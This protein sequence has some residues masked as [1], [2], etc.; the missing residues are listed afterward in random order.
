M[1]KSPHFLI[2]FQCL[3]FVLLIQPGFGQTKKINGVVLDENSNPIQGATVALKNNSATKATDAKGNFSFSVNGSKDVLRVTYV[4]YDSKEIEVGNQTSLTISL[5]PKLATLNDIVITALGFEAKKDRLGYATSKISADQITNSGEAGLLDALGGK[6]SGVRVS[7]TSGD[8]GAGSQILIR[9]QS[10]ITRGTDPLII[11]DGVPVN[12]GSRNESSGNTTQ[13]SRLN[14]INPE[15]IASMQVLKGASAAAL[16]GTK[17]ANGVL[18]ITTK[19]GGGNKTSISYKT[20]YSIDEVSAFYDLQSTYGQGL[21]GVWQANGTRSWGDKI[22]NRSGAADVF[23]TTG[24]SF[25]A[26]NGITY[27]PITTKN[28]KDIFLK[29]NYDA[30][31]HKGHYLDNSLSLSGGDNKSSYF[32]RLSDLNQEGIIR[33]G[34]SY[35]RTGFRFNTS[36]ELNKWLTVSNKASYSLINS[37]RIQTGVNN[38]GFM[39]ALLRASP[40][41]DNSGYIGKYSATS[42]GAFIENR[43]RSYRNYIG[44]SANPGFN[45]PLWDLYQLQNT[46]Q[47]NRFINS[48]EINIKPVSWFN[49]TT[50]AGVDYFTDRH[51]NYYPVY[52]TNAIAGQYNRQEFSER[53]F[54]LDVIGRAEKTFSDKFNGNILVGFNYNAL[55]TS[56]LGGQ[57]FNFIIPNGPQDLDNATPNNVSITDLFLKRRSNAGYSSIGFG[58]YDQLFVNATGRI[59]VAST[60]SELSNNS[61]F[62]PSADIAWQFTKLNA[63]KNSTVLSFGKLRASY[64]IVGIQPQAYQTATNFVVRSWQDGFGGSLDPSLYGTGTY[65]QSVNR[66]N[67]FLKP[68]RK[69]EFEIG[70]DLRFFSDKLSTSVTYYNNKTIDALI[71]ISQ[72]ASTGFDNLYANAGSIENKGIELDISYNVLRKK[73]WNVDMNVNWTRNKNKVLSLNGAG[74]INLGGTAGI[75]SRAVEG[76]ALGVLYSIPWVRNTKGNLQLDANGFPVPDVTSVPI[77]DP[78]P[79]WRGAFGF[80]VKYKNFTLSALVEHSQGGVVANGTEGVLLDYGVSAATGNESVSTTNLK[81]YNGTV[82]TAGTAFRG[83][84]YNFGGGDVALD[85][86][87]YTGPGGWFG[88]V[89]EQ[90][91]EDATWTRFRE[92]NIG[93]TLKSARLK[94]MIGLNSLGIE[95]SGRNLFLISKVKGYDPD[96]NVAGSTSARG[97]VY[98]VNPPTRSYLFTLRLNF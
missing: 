86:S 31:I 38:A 40:D 18:V 97:V 92:L 32:F 48:A 5:T 95:V 81:K 53:Q 84:I 43:Q 3:F 46:S 41:F 83:N 10:T 76:N 75:S 27:Y 12:G 60:F 73:D 22:E 13:Q 35:R 56:T 89:G 69:Q 15:D 51:I 20:T 7:R 49:L 6:S 25:I 28:S 63:L 98:F 71:N 70:T 61:F 44:A 36:K 52:S 77:G 74:S 14:D 26:N 66:G 57:S 33:K 21:N 30:V 34:S 55:N 16:W 9:G 80:N 19:K 2:L 82:I 59:E 11:L 47:V 24:A 29:Q 94:K 64:G 45:N 91:L 62:Y 8:P 96:N 54:N 65:L 85:Q 42:G 87:W 88:N 17:A 1:R 67:A 37:D 4:G 39:I 93:Y 58:L 90:F 78:N 23:N 79:D 72:P 68:E 50:R